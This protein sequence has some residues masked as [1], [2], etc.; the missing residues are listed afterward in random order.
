[1]KYFYVTTTPVYATGATTFDVTG[2][3]DLVAGA[4]TLPYYSKIESPQGFKRGE[5]WYK[6]QVTKISDQVI[7]DSATDKILLDSVIIDANNN[8]GGYKYTVPVTG[9][10][11][12]NAEYRILSYVGKLVTISG[13]IR[14]NGSPY[15]TEG[16]YP[17]YGA[18]NSWN[19]YLN[20]S[21][22]FL[23]TKGDYIELF[24]S[25]DTVDTSSAN[26]NGVLTIQFISI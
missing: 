25:C 7:T 11:S 6:A 22:I 13:H 5:I 21:R 8:F 2:E 18:G 12:I 15:V 9:Y 4:I 23:L 14:K 3:V 16:L 19:L 26:I 20:I 17:A 1:V 24:Q 10:Y